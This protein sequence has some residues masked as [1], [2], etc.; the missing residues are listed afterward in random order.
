M[1]V[2]NAQ[3]EELYDLLDRIQELS[4]RNFTPLHNQSS[5]EISSNNQ[6]SQLRNEVTEIERNLEVTRRKF[7]QVTEKVIISLK[8]FKILI[9][10]NN[11]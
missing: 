11:Y 7:Y 3:F 5:R 4:F 6:L 8:Y 10:L 9:R 1:W 2:S